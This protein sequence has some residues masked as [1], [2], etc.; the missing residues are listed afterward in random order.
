MSAG[1]LSAINTVIT[2]MTEYFGRVVVK[3]DIFIMPT[4]CLFYSFSG[5]RTTNSI[6]GLLYIHS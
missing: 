2:G 5:L 6:I 3:G 1:T 4:T